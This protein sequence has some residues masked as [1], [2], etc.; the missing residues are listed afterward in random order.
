VL[1]GAAS[2]QLLGGQLLGGQ[3]ASSISVSA[4]FS[5]VSDLE[6][7]APV[8]MADVTIGSVSSISLDGTRALVK[9]SLLKSA[10]VPAG[11]TAELRRTAIFGQRF[12]ELVHVSKA[13]KAPLLA[14]GARIANTTTLPGIQQLVS[15]GAGVFGAISS[16]DLASAVAAGAQGFGGEGARLHSLLSNLSTVM[17][18]YASRDATIRSLV[19]SMDQL[20][21][22]LAPSSQANANLAQT[23][24]ILAADAGRFETLLQALENLS[25]QG[26]SLLELYFPQMTLQLKTLYT[27]SRVLATHQAALAGLLEWIYRHDVATKNGTVNDYQ[28][29]LNDII[30]CG[31][32][33]GGSNPSQPATSC[34]TGA[35]QSSAQP[36]G[37]APGGGG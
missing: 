31:I 5:D 23:S 1:V 18:A 19:A 30:V 8:Q 7:G 28:Q 16:T 3:A 26:R 21:S 20:S 11:V 14:N 6:S 27:V 22:S 34:H 25:I 29:I 12:V 35:S 36:G 15:A 10:R 37:Q 4:V 13:A 2:Y 17:T 24:E 9:M 32:P 33:N